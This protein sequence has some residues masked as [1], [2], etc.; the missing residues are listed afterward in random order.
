MVY[1]VLDEADRMLDQGF[2]PAIEQIVKACPGP[3]VR[4]TVMFSA[5]WPEEIRALA[6]TYLKP[7]VVRVTV[8][9]PELSANHRVKQIVECLEAHEKE[10][11]LLSLLNKYHSSRSNRILIFVL[12]KK[13]AVNLQNTLQVRKNFPSIEI[14]CN[15]NKGFNVTAIHG[16][17]SQQDRTAAL[18]EFKSGRTPL[19]IATDVA[20]CEEDY[21]CLHF[22]IGIGERARYTSSGICS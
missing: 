5:T 4:Q 6:D 8:G 15:Q 21:I 19:L 7:D 11:R 12:Y 1:L 17:R 18:E 9:S 13:E 14:D 3:D 20:V 2:A 22:V 10:K 16:D